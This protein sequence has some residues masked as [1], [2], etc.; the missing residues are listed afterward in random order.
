M[1]SAALEPHVGA[2]GHQRESR[3]RR[4]LRLALLLLLRS[5]V[6]DGFD[7]A[8]GAGFAPSPRASVRR[9]SPPLLSRSF[10]GAS[11]SSRS[12]R[13][14]ARSG[15][16]HRLAEVAGRT[17]AALYADIDLELSWSEDELPQVER[18]KHVHSL[19]PYLGKFIPQL[20]EVF[21][22][23]YFTRNDCVYDPFVGSGTAL[24]ESN[25][26][27]AA[28]VGC[29]I[30]AFNCLLSRVKT[31]RYSLAALELALKGALEDARRNDTAPDD[32][33][34]EWLRAWY[35]DRALGELLA[36]R[37]AIAQLDDPI[38]DVGRV[39][40]SRSARSARRTTHFDLDFPRAPQT[41]PYWCH[42]HRRTCRPV[43][44]AS[45][46]LRRYTLDTIRR[47]REFSLIGS[48]ADS[49]VLHA[50]ARE[51][52]LPVE[53]SGI[54]TSPPYPGLIDYHEQHRYAYELLG[55]VDRRTEEI[56]PASRGQSR[57][58][59]RAYVEDMI[60]VFANAHRQLPGGAPVIIVVNDSKALYPEILDRSGVSLS[61]RLTRH[62]N[63]RTGRRAGEFYEDAL[64]CST[65]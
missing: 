13:H 20:V 63:R 61:E 10:P 25:V 27:G 38:R 23:R 19:H 65:R 32:Q 59:V 21:L 18:T 2:P 34:S 30:S 6:A 64:V 41:E 50:D 42:K 60:A 48:G 22:R 9:C 4:P 14:P 43:D 53:P 58:A 35:S 51:V 36:Y 37:E 33:T 3:S 16:P 28:S 39:I 1:R 7:G 46:F 62:V 31:A 49:L 52:D 40:L 12:E 44:E 17:Q 55:L 24:V 11:C 5:V 15:A 45:K 8:R 57:R 56:G 47:L 29:D 54:I 26:F